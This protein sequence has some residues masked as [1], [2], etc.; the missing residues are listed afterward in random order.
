MLVYSSAV[1]QL[2]HLNL[3]LKRPATVQC[4]VLCAIN[5]FAS[6]SKILKTKW[7]ASF[8]RRLTLLTHLRN[9]KQSRP[10]E[11]SVRHKTWRIET[12]YRHRRGR[13]RFQTSPLFDFMAPDTCVSNVFATRSSHSRRRRSVFCLLIFRS[14]FNTADFV[15]GDEKTRAQTLAAIVCDAHSIANGKRISY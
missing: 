10:A 2:T 6:N 15:S 1:C 4:P 5:R 14:L 13:G 9:K 3:A 12:R 7:F 11:G 8:F